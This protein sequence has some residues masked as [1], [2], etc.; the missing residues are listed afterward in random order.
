[1]PPLARPFPVGAALLIAAAAAAQS[2]N[3]PGEDDNGPEPAEP[4]PGWTRPRPSP[5]GCPARAVRVAGVGERRGYTAHF[6]VGPDGLVYRFRVEPPAPKQ[7]E[8]ALREEVERCEWSPG[9]NPEGEPT[10]VRVA[11]AFEVDG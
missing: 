11:A 2:G 3:G 10:T 5:E 1:M 9:R 6:A 7:V 4:G 8:A